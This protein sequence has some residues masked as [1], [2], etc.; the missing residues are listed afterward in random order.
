MFYSEGAVDHFIYQ[1]YIPGYGELI[2]ADSMFQGRLTRLLYVDGAMQSATYNEPDERC[3]LIFEYM[4]GFDD[5]LC[6]R[7]DASDILLIGGG[8]MSYPK[9]FI[10]AFPDKRLDVVEMCPE[11]IDIARRYFY[12]DRD[13]ESRIGLYLTDGDSFL[14]ETEKTYDIIF[15]DA[16]IGSRWDKTI[17]GNTHCRL[18]KRRLSPSGIYVLNV[19]TAQKGLFSMRGKKLLSTLR[20]FFKRTMFIPCQEEDDYYGK[21]NCLV[22]ASDGELFT[23]K[24]R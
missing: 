6:M 11:M 10:H 20:R 23:Q 4:K 14:S 12:L 15:N 5:I 3:V 21:Q 19:I 17:T 1:N 22:L 24:N 9:H 18:I 7:P 16:Y 8:A 13:T 2:V